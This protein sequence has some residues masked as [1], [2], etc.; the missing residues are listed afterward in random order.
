MTNEKAVPLRSDPEAT[1]P[2][3][4][5]IV[6][7]VQPEMARRSVE[8]GTNVMETIPET[9]SHDQIRERNKQFWELQLGSEPEE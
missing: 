7:G 8:F 3:Q 4:A 1:E 5:P 2:D 9:V 6:P